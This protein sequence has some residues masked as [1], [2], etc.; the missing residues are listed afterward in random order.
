MKILKEWKRR[1]GFQTLPNN[2]KFN[3][4][5][6]WKRK[7]PKVQINGVVKVFKGTKEHKQT[8]YRL[9]K[10]KETLEI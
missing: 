8:Y 5:L 1:K 7:R 4:L 3:F 6:M 10:L 2:K 9:Q